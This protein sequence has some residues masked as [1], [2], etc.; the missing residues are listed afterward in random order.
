MLLSSP[1]VDHPPALEPGADGG[2]RLLP[3]LRITEGEGL[4]C[5]E[6][7]PGIPGRHLGQRIQDLGGH[8]SLPL[9][10]GGVLRHRT[11]QYGANPLP[12]KGRQHLHPA[13]R[14]EGR[15]E[16]EGGVLRGRPQQAHGTLFEKGEERVML[17]LVEAV[18]LVHEEDRDEALSA[19]TVPR[20]SHDL[21]DLLEPAQHGRK[22]HEGPF[23]EG[24]H[25]PG[26][27]G[28]AA[29]GGAPEDCGDEGVGLDLL[30]ESAPRPDHRF[31]A[32]QVIEAGGPHALRQGRGLVLR[33]EEGHQSSAK[34]AIIDHLAPWV[35]SK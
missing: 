1:V 34:A 26:D 14:E 35:S 13:P 10:D 12:G 2:G 19:P 7:E 8:T 33:L 6:G 29:A 31:E 27:G 18:D 28:L 9:P 5:V 21:P 30:A 17:R 4:E 16:L 3:L 11:I 32:H 22:G 15:G 24:L 25:Q 23:G 20:A